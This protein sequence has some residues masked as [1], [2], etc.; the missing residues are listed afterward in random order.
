MQLRKRVL[1]GERGSL[2][3]ALL[4]VIVLG[5]L[6]SVLVATVVAGQRQTRFDQSFENSLQIAEVGLDRLVYLV[7]HDEVEEGE[8]FVE[9]EGQA[10]GGSYT[11][12]ATFDAQEHEWTIESRGTSNSGI[13]RA[14]EVVVAPQSIFQVAAFGKFF[15]DFNGGNATD[16]YRS[17]DFGVDPNGA[18]T[19]TQS[20]NGGWPCR[21]QPYGRL[22]ATG[23]GNSNVVMCNDLGNGIVATNG[24]LNLKGNAFDRAD[25][26]EV[27]FAK[28][29][30]DDPHEDATGFCAMTAARCSDPK[31]SY[32]RDKL[33]VEPDPV[34][35]P[36]T[37][38]SGGNFPD[39]H[40]DGNV[41]APGVYLFADVRLNS[42]TQILGTATDPVVIYMTGTLSMPNH[43]TVNFETAS[44]GN[45]QP[46]P[47]PSLR[48]YSNSDGNQALNFGNH[49]SIAGA[50]YAPNA[51]F[52]GGA[53]GNVYGS[54]IAGSINNNGGW[55]FH[56][57]EALGD[58]MDLAPLRATNWAEQ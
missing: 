22:T 47:S 36:E 53:Q 20:S 27:H 50:I 41:L 56:Y 55:N 18:L 33:E 4:A 29:R 6:V 21:R 2:P 13:S 1:V 44:D 10:S 23:S 8:D 40:P 42:E 37:L 14:V 24:E 52:A 57:D 19:F 54:L 35:I 9:I 49:A 34:P 45:P 31:V 17:G 30:V 39:D 3:L 48:I 25:L 43:T 58:V 12:T 5:G 46:R 11:A 26:A 32:H 15:V 7:T 51:G 38:S 16:S 28:E